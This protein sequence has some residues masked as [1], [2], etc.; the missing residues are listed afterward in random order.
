MGFWFYQT[1]L[2]Q[3]V[4]VA[5][6]AISITILFISGFSGMILSWLDKNKLVNYLIVFALTSPLVLIPTVVQ[7]RYRFQIYPFLAIFG[8]YFLVACW[9]KNNTLGR[10]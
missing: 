5:S 4:F 10:A 1:G 2:S 8:G 6:S 3:L 7:S 9:Y